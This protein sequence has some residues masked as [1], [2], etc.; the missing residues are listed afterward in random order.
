MKN[1]LPLTLTL[2]LLA[3]GAEAKKKKELKDSPLPKSQQE[4]FLAKTTMP[5]QFNYSVYRVKD[6]GFGCSGEARLHPNHHATANFLEKGI[7]VIKMQGSSRRDKVNVLLDTSSPH[8]WLEFAASQELS[9]YFLGIN[10]K[11]IP[12]R[13][14]YNT[15]GVN[16]YLGVIKQMRIDQ[17]FIESIP[18]YVRMS[19]GSLG[20]LTRGIKEPH[21][22]A[23]LGYD[24]LKI[25]EYIQFDL[26][27]NKVTFSATKP[28]EPPSEEESGV[29][30]TKII[31]S[32]S[33]GLVVEG[34]VNDEESPMIIDLAGNF[35]F[36]RGD[37][38]VAITPAIKLGS[39]EMLDAS[40]LVLPLHD[41]PPRVGRKL[42]EPYLITICNK[43]GMVYFEK[44][45]DEKKKKD[46][47]DS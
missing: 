46:K 43:K 4:H 16:A 19:I 13:G 1:F 20:P 32:R 36:A 14:N 42:L 34:S 7:P 22:D 45:P 40:T 37:I 41:S 5:Q 28:F 38:K 15:G 27:N 29:Y 11:A 21:I 9:V 10:D 33:Y 6:G 39:L 47:A 25:F 17:L 18:F 26:R 3:G 44:H 8:S 35:S 12:Y 31:P 30:S 2:V 24:N 23:I